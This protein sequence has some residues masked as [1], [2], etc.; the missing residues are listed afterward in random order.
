MLQS[1]T[2]RPGLLVSLKTTIVGNVKYDKR[3]IEAEHRLKTGEAKARWET[4]RIIDDPDEHKRAHETRGKARSLITGV[5][6]HSA[7]GLLCPENSAEDLE[8]RVAEARGVC[9]RFNRGAKLSR[10]NV[11]VITGRI[12]PDDVEAVRAINSEVRELLEQMAEGVRNL[13]AK[14]IR[15]AASR[16]KGLGTMLSPDAEVRVKLAIESARMAARK[17]VA[18][19]EQ[20]A[21]E[22]DRGAIKR[23]TEQRTA[24]LDLDESAP[25]KVAK[26]TGRAVD[27]TPAAPVKAKRAPARAAEVE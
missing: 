1:S 13:D 3:T 18:A 10:V 2:L 21:Q 11:Y 8:A 16:A 23:I 15:D 20:A 25:I 4:V 12:A 7:F 5:C 19:G 22:I 6:A 27:L 17:I 24:F 9:E 14:S 26:S